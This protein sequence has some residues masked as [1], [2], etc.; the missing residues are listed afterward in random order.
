MENR[1][2]KSSKLIYSFMNIK[3]YLPI[4]LLF[5]V[6]ILSINIIEPGLAKEL[7]DKS[8][9]ST[10]PSYL[11]KIGAVWLGL[12][13]FKI[14]NMYIY[15]LI[16]LK[17]KI[18]VYH[19]IKLSLYQKIINFPI[20]YFQ[21]N[22]T[23]YI[24]SRILDDVEGI[25]GMLLHNIINGLISL[26][27]V[28]IIFTL[29]LNVNVMLT[30]IVFIM[31]IVYTVCQ[32][33]FPLTRL[34]KEHNE[35][36]STVSKELGDSLDGI[37][38]IKSFSAEVYESN[39]FDN[40]LKN[41]DFNRIN[42]DEANIK[43]LNLVQF[44]SGC[45]NPVIIIIGGILIFKKIITTGEVMAFILYFE[46]LRTALV[47]GMN[48]IPCYKVGQASA[49]RIFEIFK[50]DKENLNIERGL[51]EVTDGSIEFKNVTFGYEEDKIILNNVNFKINKGEKIGF[52]GVSGSGKSSI[53][54]LILKFFN[55]NKGEILINNI[56]INKYNISNLRRSIGFVHQSP[57][58]FNR[59]LREN[60]QYINKLDENELINILQKA[61]IYNIITDNKVEFD[62]LVEQN[63][64]MFSGGEKQRLCIAR[65][66]TKKPKILILDE[67][68][69]S[70]DSISENCIEKT[71]NTMDKDVTVIIIAHRLATVK[72][73]DRIYVLEQGN[74]IEEGN[75]EEL[76]NNKGKYYELFN[77]QSSKVEGV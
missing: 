71:I 35:S 64:N 36:K 77:K 60:L 76:L 69:S 3:R 10:S 18:N 21:K 41:Y 6:I 62:S 5:E 8:L 67:A 50:M 52:V 29:M 24:M 47:P 31:T 74:I 7:I 13:L 72:N 26:L 54:K 37:N 20:K 22:S 65:E 11:I 61:Y 42:R 46:K 23:G 49:Q 16:T 45:I 43:R 40:I 2:V 70:L 68:T 34:Y 59:I 19:Q 17:F 12:Y 9:M 1:F 44:I 57:F 14:I 48:L 32:F 51:N 73:L 75:H 56:N 38:V 53:V 39:R 33:I 27:Q 66:L 63:G 55:V 15:Q 30:L 25:D 58:L 28:I 4:F